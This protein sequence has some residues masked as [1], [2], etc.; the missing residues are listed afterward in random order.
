MFSYAEHFQCCIHFNP[1]TILEI[2]STK[3]KIDLSDN[4]LFKF[5]DINNSQV[6][7]YEYSSRLILRFAGMTPDNELQISL[8]NNIIV[9]TGGKSRMQVYAP[10]I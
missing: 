9:T 3:L 7:N 1:D 5:I 4:A 10:N 2:M 8:Q 6:I